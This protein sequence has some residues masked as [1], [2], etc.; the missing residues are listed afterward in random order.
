M[1]RTF[2]PAA[3]GGRPGR[4]SGSRPSRARVSARAGPPR[5]SRRRSRAGRAARSSP[6][7]SAHL[8]VRRQVGDELVD[9]RPELVGEVRR[10]RADE[11]VDVLAGGLVRHRA[12]PNG[13]RVRSSGEEVERGRSDA[14]RGRSPL[15]AQHL[16]HA[17]R[18]HRT[19]SSRSPTRRSATAPRSSL[20]WIFTWWRERSFRVARRRPQARLARRAADLPQPGLVRHLGSPDERLDGRARPR[21]DAVFVGIFATAGRARAARAGVLDR[22]RRLVRRASG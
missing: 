2:T 6:R 19:A 13:G 5:P 12:K 20:F 17:V 16:G 11:S 3:A 22:R 4:R 9:A 7:R 10:R 8:V 14:A 18:G 21:D 15:G 1:T